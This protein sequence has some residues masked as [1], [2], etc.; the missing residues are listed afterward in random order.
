MNELY[1]LISK[2]NMTTCFAT[3]TDL[4]QAKICL[5]ALNMN[6]NENVIL[7]T[8]HYEDSAEYFMNKYSENVSCIDNKSEKFDYIKMLEDRLDYVTYKKTYP[9]E[10]K[11]I[12]TG[13]YERYN[14]NIGTINEFLSVAKMFF[15][16]NSNQ[17]FKFRNTYI[18]PND[19]KKLEDAK[20]QWQNDVYEAKRDLSEAK[21]KKASEDDDEYYV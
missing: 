12:H 5:D 8:S 16:S 21:I 20:L 2:N 15:Q 18:L 13:S 9:I 10:L 1:E 6:G 4:R 19:T 7:V 11:S 3:F 17:G 14:F